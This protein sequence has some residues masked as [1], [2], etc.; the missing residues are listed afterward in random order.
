MFEPQGH[1]EPAMTLRGDRCGKLIKG[2]LVA[3]EGAVVDVMIRNLSAHGMGGYV[4]GQAPREGTTVQIVIEKVGTFTGTVRWRRGHTFGFQCD[5][6]IDV[7]AV[8]TSLRT[9]YEASTTSTWQMSDY[10]K[11]PQPKP[12]GVLRRV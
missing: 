10:Y 6:E 2:H 7:A 1:F 9:H 11:I 4:R 12:Q 3:A 5:D 8:A